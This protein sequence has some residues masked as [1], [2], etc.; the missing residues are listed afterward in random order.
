MNVDKITKL[1]FKSHYNFELGY[2]ES[3]K[4]L[5]IDQSRVELESP[6]RKGFNK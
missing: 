1:S 6:N 2:R 4:T 5:K 3:E